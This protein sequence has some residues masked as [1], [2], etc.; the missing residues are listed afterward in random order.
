MNL[1]ATAIQ[2][3]D[4]LRAQLSAAVEQ[5]LANGG[6]IHRLGH[7]EHAPM[8]PATYNNRPPRMSRRERERIEHMV[9]EHA[10]AYASMGL[11][12]PQAVSRLRQQWAGRYVVTTLRLEQ[13]AAAHGFFFREPK[14]KEPSE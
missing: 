8:R 10:R 11:T 7:T 2:R 13:L 5:Y 14:R 3:R 9:A 6:R 1:N 4:P 12:L